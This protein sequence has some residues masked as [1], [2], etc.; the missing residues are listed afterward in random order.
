MGLTGH[1][2]E[3]VSP[4]HRMSSRQTWRQVLLYAYM[5]IYVSLFHSQIAAILSSCGGRMS[6]SEYSDYDDFERRLQKIFAEE[7]REKQ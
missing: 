6:A 7:K 4:D 2:S 5:A 3:K 1:G